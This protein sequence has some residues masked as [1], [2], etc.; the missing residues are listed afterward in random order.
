MYTTLM[1][2]NYVWRG[3]GV[4]GGGLEHQGHAN[5]FAEMNPINNQAPGNPPA[6]SAYSSPYY[7][8]LKPPP[9][10]YRQKKAENV[11]KPS[12]GAP[13]TIG[14]VPGVNMRDVNTDGRATGP[15]Q[16][17][18]YSAEEIP[19]LMAPSEVSSNSDTGDVITRDV[20][21][22]EERVRYNYMFTNQVY[23]GSIG[24][25]EQ[26]FKKETREEERPFEGTWEPHAV[27]NYENGE[28]ND[29]VQ[30][31]NYSQTP[32]E[33]YENLYEDQINPFSSQNVGRQE[34][35]Q[36]VEMDTDNEI[37][38]I[39]DRTTAVVP[40]VSKGYNPHYFDE[41]GT[42]HGKKFPET[43]RYRKRK[44]VEGQQPQKKL[45]STEMTNL[46][47]IK[48]QNKRSSSSGYYA[49]SKKRITGKDAEIRNQIA[50]GKHFGQKAKYVK[51]EVSKGQKRKDTNTQGGVVKKRFVTMSN[52]DLI[53]S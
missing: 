11:N 3:G 16:R 38:N 14:Y 36:P 20:I 50:R 26:T 44:R 45:N 13:A 23:P 30:M 40:K 34:K 51:L 35:H 27:T 2:K 21:T 47:L 32:S 22:P 15:G 41:M 12:P 42:I 28:R 39:V 19:E 37:A 49:V 10:K 29:D 46:D 8:D 6:P 52:E 17:P 18:A 1:I 31:S 24:L 7:G 25:D 43:T 53:S 33:Q 5:W 4:P 9:I 48:G